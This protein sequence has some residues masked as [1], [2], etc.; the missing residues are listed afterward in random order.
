M[1]VVK[2]GG[3]VLGGSSAGPAIDAARIARLWAE[4]EPW[5]AEIVLVHGAG[6]YPRSVLERA[7]AAAAERTSRLRDALAEVHAEL[8]RALERSGAAPRALPPGLQRESAAVG[9][10]LA[11]RRLPLGRGDVLDAPGGNPTIVSSDRV[12]EQLARDL[13]AAEVLWITDVDGVLDV[14]GRLLERVGAGSLDAIDRRHADEAD[15]TAGMSGKLAAA[16]RLAAAGIPSR[17]VNGLVPG[18][19][20]AA[21]G[22]GPWVGTRVG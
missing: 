17:I 8:A 10:A 11:G 12:A 16:L 9:E 2:L 14:R 1:R 7:D 15:P 3:S 19:V 4:L 13:G 22:G 5:A 6:R 20:A 21:L 18:R